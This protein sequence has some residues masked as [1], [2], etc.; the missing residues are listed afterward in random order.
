MSAQLVFV[1]ALGEDIV[2]EQAASK[3]LLFIKPNKSGVSPS[4]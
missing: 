2:P 4:K 3:D 1:S